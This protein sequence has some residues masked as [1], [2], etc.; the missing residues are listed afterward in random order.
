MGPLTDAELFQE[1]ARR[2]AARGGGEQE[3][4]LEDGP[5]GYTPRPSNLSGVRGAYAIYMIGDE[6]FATCDTCTH[7][8]ASLSEDGYIEDCTVIC[9]WHDGA[10]D[11]RTGE[12]AALPCM[13]AIQT[14]KVSVDGDEVFVEV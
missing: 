5:I 8:Q 13:V 10:F 12:P 3:M 4:F 7:G 9:S 2:S 11:L 6:L 14:Y 1:A